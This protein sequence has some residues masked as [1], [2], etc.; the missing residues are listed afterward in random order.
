MKII[1]DTDSQQSIFDAIKCGITTPEAI[2]EYLCVH[3]PD[4]GYDYDR[5]TDS[6]IS[7][8]WWTNIHDRAHCPHPNCKT[9]Y[10]AAVERMEKQL[11]RDDDVGRVD[12]L[13]YRL[14]MS[15]DGVQHTAITEVVGMDIPVNRKLL[16]IKQAAGDRFVCGYSPEE[17]EWTTDGEGG[18]DDNPGA[19]S[20]GGTAMAF[21]SHCRDCGLHRREVHYGTQR[22]P[23][24][25]DV[26]DYAMLPEEVI[27]DYIAK[28]YM[29][30]RK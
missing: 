17:H 20:L 4:H 28:G 5:D 24:Q 13:C 21:R 26:V 27:S 7:P 3:A 2:H 16:P 6:L 10:E 9:H 1:I 23:G 30:E 25:S 11:W 12:V 18:S 14:G 8:L 19:F 22:N 29:D 15:A